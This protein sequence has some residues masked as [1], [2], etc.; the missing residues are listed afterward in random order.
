MRMAPQ[1]HVGASGGSGAV[2]RARSLLRSPLDPLPKFA[3]AEGED[4][5]RFF[6]N[7]EE[8]LYKYS[9]PEYDKR[10]LLK[11][12]IGGRA[13]TLV[14]SLKA[15]RQDYLHAKALLLKVLVSE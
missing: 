1:T 3:S 15:D 13:L 2:D 9:Y 11:Q 10:L 14:N 5:T 6:S 7:L 8:T 12:Q 4:L